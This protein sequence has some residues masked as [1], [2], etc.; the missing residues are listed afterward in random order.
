MS[1]LP[2]RGLRKTAHACHCEE[3]EA[4]K[5]SSFRA[6][7]A[8]RSL[9]CACRRARNDRVPRMFKNEVDEP[10]IP[11]FLFLN[12]KQYCLCL[13]SWFF[14]VSKPTSWYDIAE[15]ILPVLQITFRTGFLR[16]A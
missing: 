8:S 1:V 2:A 13:W 6:E 15:K 5:Q 16:T 10:L 4:T 12:A 7:I 11:F 3:P 14:E 9:S